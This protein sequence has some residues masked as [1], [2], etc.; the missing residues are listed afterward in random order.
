MAF[1][2]AYIVPAWGDQLLPHRLMDQL[3][4]L[5]IQCRHIELMRGGV[6][7]NFLLQNDSYENLTFCP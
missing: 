7:F 6:W 5:P 2:Y 4:T 3:D 1:V